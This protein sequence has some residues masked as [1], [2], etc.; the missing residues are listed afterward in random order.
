MAHI[1]IMRALCWS[2]SEDEDEVARMPPIIVPEWDGMTTSCL[3]KYGKVRR[4]DKMSWYD[5]QELLEGIPGTPEYVETHEDSYKV[6]ESKKHK[7][8]RERYK[9]NESPKKTFSFSR[10]SNGTRWRRKF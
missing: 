3:F 6:V 7:R 10:T 9:K 8:A 2:E 1:E 5:W 4:P